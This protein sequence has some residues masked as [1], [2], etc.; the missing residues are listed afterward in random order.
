M[1]KTILELI[2][3]LFL[4]I[5]AF[6]MGKKA[7]ERADLKRAIKLANKIFDLKKKPLKDKENDIHRRD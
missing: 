1:I 3:T 2:K 4:P 5:M 6:F 7:A